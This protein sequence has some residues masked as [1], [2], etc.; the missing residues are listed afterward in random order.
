MANWPREIMRVA[1]MS[2]ARAE[3][4]EK[5]AIPESAALKCALLTKYERSE[6]DI[7][8]TGPRQP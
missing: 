8:F 7:E 4:A 3:K 6:N 5:C 2:P 1:G